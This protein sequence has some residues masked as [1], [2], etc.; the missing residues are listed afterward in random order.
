MNPTREFNF[1]AAP[2]CNTHD[3]AHAQLYALH[4]RKKKPPFVATA[5]NIDQAWT[6]PR[7]NLDV[8]QIN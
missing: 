2:E 6:R 4:C 1:S 3:A 8:D 5:A 7:N